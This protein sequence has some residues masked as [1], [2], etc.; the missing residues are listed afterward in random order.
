MILRPITGQRLICWKLLQYLQQLQQ[1]Q[2]QLTIPGLLP[3]RYILILQ[4]D[5]FFVPFPWFL[6]LF[7]SRKLHTFKRMLYFNIKLIWPTHDTGC[8]HGIAVWNRICGHHLWRISGLQQKWSRFV[9]GCELVGG[10]KYWGKIY[11]LPPGFAISCTQFLLELILIFC[12]LL[13]LI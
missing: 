5:P 7:F 8:C 6:K 3:I 9:N 12:R 1:G 13:Q 10:E 2:Q 11:I 4:P